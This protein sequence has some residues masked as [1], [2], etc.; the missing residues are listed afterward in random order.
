[1][2]AAAE[3]DDAWLY[4]ENEKAD[5]ENREEGGDDSRTAAEDSVVVIIKDEVPQDDKEAGEL[6]CEDDQQR[7][8]ETSVDAAEAE[9]DKE[10]ATATADAE[11]NGDGEIGDDDDEDDDDDDDD[12]QV[13]IRDIKSAPYAAYPGPP[14]TVNLNI[15]RGAPFGGNLGPG[16]GVGPG[17]AKTKGLDVDEVA[18][19]NGVSIYEFNIE[20]LE[21][22]PWRKPGADITD[23]FNYGFNEDTW[24]IYC[25]RQRKLR[26]DNNVP[27]KS[28]LHLVGKDPLLMPIPPVNENSKY[29]GM[30]SVPVLGSKKAGPPPGRKMSGSIDV[31]GGGA[32]SLPSRRPGGGKEGVIQLNPQ[33]RKIIAGSCTY[34]YGVL[35]ECKHSAAVVHYVNK[36]EVAACTSLPQAWGKPSKKPKLDDKASIADLFG[37]LE[38]EPK[39]RPL[40]E[41]KVRG[42]VTEVG[43]LVHNGKPWLCGGAVGFFGLTTGTV[44]LERVDL[45]TVHEYALS[46]DGRLI[47]EKT[48]DIPTV[49]ATLFASHY[50]LN[51][52]YAEG[53]TSTLEFFQK[54][55]LSMDPDRGTRAKQL[56]SEVNMEVLCLVK[57]IAEL[58]CNV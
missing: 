21:D 26:S 40:F 34:R 7:T 25:D 32:P 38:T 12:V 5:A 41:G 4:G 1:M 16:G 51:I 8:D 58:E 55:F 48:P 33:S 45:W 22:K 18:L 44:L 29:T 43:L 11:K 46:I 49:C 35:G 42:H 14:P 52:C 53:L 9:Q 3:D 19:L 15:K 50:C 54:G 36:H 10:A 17:G 56:K 39:A 2:A 37:G 23:Y 57:N 20:S 27:V 47:F 24:K 28:A 6:S 31:I 13:T 30:A